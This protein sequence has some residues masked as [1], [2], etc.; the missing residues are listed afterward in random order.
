MERKNWNCWPT[1]PDM[2]NLKARVEAVADPDDREIYDAL[3]NAV[4]YY[5]DQSGRHLANARKYAAD[6]QSISVAADL[7]LKERMLVLDLFDKAKVRMAALENRVKKYEAMLN[8]DMK[9]TI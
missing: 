1:A 8:T 5:K 6:Y 4:E 9:G 2:D 7:V 3:L